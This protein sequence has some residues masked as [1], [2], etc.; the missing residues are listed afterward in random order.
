MSLHNRK[1]EDSGSVSPVLWQSEYSVLDKG[2]PEGLTLNKYHKFCCCL[3][4]KL[5]PTL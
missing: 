1:P 3:V 2:D 4:T 5:C